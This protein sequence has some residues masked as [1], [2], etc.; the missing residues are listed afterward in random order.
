MPFTIVHKDKTRIP[1]DTKVCRIDAISEVGDNLD[2]YTA[3]SKV[4]HEAVEPGDR[5]G[6]ISVRS[7]G[8]PDL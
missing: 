2:L 6:G 3:Y 4:L 8:T 1:S 7:R 5:L